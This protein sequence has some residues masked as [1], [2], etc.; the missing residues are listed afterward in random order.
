MNTSSRIVAFWTWIEGCR[1][2][3]DILRHPSEPFWGVILE[4]LHRI[5]DGIWFELGN[6]PDGSREL[7]FTSHGDMTIFSTIDAL[8]TAAP[9][10]PAWLFIALRPAEGMM[11]HT[12]GFGVEIEPDE[13]WFMRLRHP[14][15]PDILG[16]RVAMP[17]FV[18]GMKSEPYINAAWRIIDGLLGERRT[19]TFVK[20]VEV[21]ERPSDPEALR[22]QHISTL[23]QH[24]P[25]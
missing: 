12:S 4:Q 13:V 7:V 6:N 5:D 10:W 20:H 23:P 21:C 25:S 17:G 1:D 3:L 11:T 18:T 22:F 15:K 9:S 14:T 24:V 2:E 19:A 16:L 8:V